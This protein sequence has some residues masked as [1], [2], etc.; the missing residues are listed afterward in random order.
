M[1]RSHLACVLLSAWLAIGNAAAAC[2]GCDTAG[3][4]CCSRSCCD[5]RGL[6]DI[7][8]SLAVRFQSNLFDSRRCNRHACD[9]IACG[10]ES[11]AACQHARRPAQ[12]APSVAPYM[13]LDQDRLPTGQGFEPAPAPPRVLSPETV[14]E[15]LPMRD[16]QVDPFQD[17]TASHVRRVPARTIQ[18][19]KPREMSYGD[20]YDPQASWRRERPGSRSP[21]V[22][23][24]EN[25]SSRNGVVRLSLSDLDSP[26]VSASA[27]VSTRQLSPLPKKT[28]QRLPPRRDARPTTIVNPLRN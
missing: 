19:H 4:C 18:Y 14:P 21:R 22:S 8:D 11:R 20:S 5:D 15:P 28:V 6:L 3:P 1:K 2:D 27:K 26:V 25:T 7:V 10:C 9:E 16:Q 13:M 24:A 12:S 23:L 17:D